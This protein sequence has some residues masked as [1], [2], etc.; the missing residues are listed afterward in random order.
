MDAHVCIRGNRIDRH[1]KKR[2]ESLV[3]DEVVAF[4]SDDLVALDP[5][6]IGDSLC[7]KSCGIN[8]P[9]SLESIIAC[10]YEVPSILFCN[11]GDLMGE[12]VLNAILMGILRD[13]YRIQERIEYAGIL[14]EHGE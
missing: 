4:A 12:K 2:P 1:R 6:H 14:R 5:K 7:S 9:V 3:E 10:G 8:H 11:R 13:M